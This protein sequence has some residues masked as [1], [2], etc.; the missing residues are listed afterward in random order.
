MKGMNASRP[1]ERT[2]ESASEI[3]VDIEM[4]CQREKSGA[5]GESDPSHSG[6]GILMTF[7]A[8][9]KTAVTTAAGDFD[10][11]RQMQVGATRSGVDHYDSRDETRCEQGC[12]DDAPRLLD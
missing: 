10:P 11:S 4:R 1:W 3:G 6:S 5:F 7:P 12:P 2:A 9:L 8:R